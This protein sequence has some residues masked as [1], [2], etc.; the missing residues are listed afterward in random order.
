M[1]PQ[2]LAQRIGVPRIDEIYRAPE[3]RVRDALVRRQLDDRGITAFNEAFELR[4]ARKPVFSGDGKIGVAEF[5]RRLR[6]LFVAQSTHSR[7]KL[8]KALQHL[9][10][11]R[12]L[13]VE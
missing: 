5:E 11:T 3:V 8:A 1:M 13:T 4:P 2:V 7:M 10:N 6:D 9:G 12:A